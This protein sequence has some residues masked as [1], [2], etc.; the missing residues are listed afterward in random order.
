[1]RTSDDRVLAVGDVARVRPRGVANAEDGARNESWRA[2]KSQGERAAF[3]ILGR[4]APAPDVPWMWS[5]LGRLHLQAAGA[6][7]VEQLIVRGDLADRHG[8]CFVGITSGRVR[9]VGGAGLGGAVARLVRSGQGLMEVEARVPLDTLSSAADATALT[10]TL[11]EAYRSA[12]RNA[13]SGGEGGAS[14]PR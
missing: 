8:A 14:A 6:G 3:A 13:A 10:K 2:A 1:M 7:P 4:R 5:D 11:V 9:W 12:R